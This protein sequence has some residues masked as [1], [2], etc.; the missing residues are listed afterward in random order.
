MLP[1]LTLK[2]QVFPIK[3]SKPIKIVAFFDTRASYM[4]MN[5]DVLLAE[6]W[7]GK[8]KYFHVANNEIFSTK[9][10]S[11]PIKIQFFPGC[12]MIHRGFGSK[13]L[14]KNLIVGFDIYTKKKGLRILP[15]GLAYKQHFA[16]WESLPNYFNLFEEPFQEV[17]KRLIEG[18]C[19]KSHSGFLKN[20]IIFMEE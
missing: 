15:K 13:L 16:L 4:I 10:I 11:K 8:K 7:K 20:L 3:Y 5:P 12:T 2:V 1:V 9:L 14:R 17:K 6:Y 18:S 19:A